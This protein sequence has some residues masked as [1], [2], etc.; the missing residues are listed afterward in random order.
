MLVI[1]MSKHRLLSAGMYQEEPCNTRGQSL[2]ARRVIILETQ[3][4][5]HL[6]AHCSASV[7][8]RRGDVQFGS[9]GEGKAGTKRNQK[10]K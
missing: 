4:Q 10:T 6:A 3:K 1:S 9:E 5:N 7:P 2:Q 8:F